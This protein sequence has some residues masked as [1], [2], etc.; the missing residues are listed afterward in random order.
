[1]MLNLKMCCRNVEMVEHGTNSS[2]VMD[3]CSMLTNYA[4]QM[5]LFVFCCYRRCMEE[6][7]WDTSVS[8][9][10]RMFLLYTSFGHACGEMLR[11]SWHAALLVNK[12][13]V[14]LIPVEAMEEEFATLNVASIPHGGHGRRIPCRT[15]RW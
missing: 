2:L 11:D 4:S 14:A 9:R 1:M 13:S 15:S 6:A 7:Y 12:L 10:W 5:V 8:R 3:L